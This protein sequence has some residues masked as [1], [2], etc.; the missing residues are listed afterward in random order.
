M[1]IRRHDEY[2]PVVGHGPCVNL[3]LLLLIPEQKRTHDI[4][5]NPKTTYA[6]LTVYD[7]Y[8]T[9]PLILRIRN[10]TYTDDPT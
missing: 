6:L 9:V 8:R 5:R 7:V 2:T 4:C 1:K 3:C 10:Q